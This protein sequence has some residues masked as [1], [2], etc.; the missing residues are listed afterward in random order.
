MPFTQK[1]LD[2]L[3]ASGNIRGYVVKGGKEKVKQERQEPKG[4]AHIMGVLD[5]LGIPYVKEHR[6]HSVR[7]F[8]FDVAVLFYKLAVEYDGL[9]LGGAS[10]SRHTTIGGFSKDLEKM[11]LA[12]S[13]GWTVLRYTAL[14][15][16]QFETD[17][18]TIINKEK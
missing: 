10:K 5:R 9:A 12:Q 14:N 13:E 2:Q 8:R 11:N 17:L 15:Y 18:L 4:L 6:F 1:Q 16:K 3:V 7:K